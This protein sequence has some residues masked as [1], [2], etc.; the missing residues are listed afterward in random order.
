MDLTQFPILLDEVHFGKNVHM[1]QLYT[2][3][4]GEGSAENGNELAGV[5]AVMRIYQVNSSQLQG[6]KERIRE[7]GE[8]Q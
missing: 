3:H 5:C 6:A 7:E 2:Q 8:V 4:C 1:G